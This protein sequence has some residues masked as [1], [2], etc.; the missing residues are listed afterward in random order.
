MASR[1]LPYARIS[2]NLEEVLA[3]VMAGRS[4]WTTMLARGG[5]GSLRL[6]GEELSKEVATLFLN[7]LGWPRGGCHLC[8]GKTRPTTWSILQW[9]RCPL[10]EVKLYLLMSLRKD[11]GP[12]LRYIE[13][14]VMWIV[15]S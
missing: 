13:N 15:A 5:H 10:V 3:A 1:R 4:S 11:L 12:W 6:Q 14:K 7:E 9:Q 8:R 2:E